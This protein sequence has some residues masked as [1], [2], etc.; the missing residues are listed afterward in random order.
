MI[1]H[2]PRDIIRLGRSFLLSLGG[3]GLQSGF[4]FV[5]NLLLIRLLSPHDFG[6]FAIAFVLGGI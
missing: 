2:I 4:H 5:L 1:S 6:V 3:E